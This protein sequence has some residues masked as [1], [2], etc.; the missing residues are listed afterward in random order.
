MQGAP[1]IR[2]V[3]AADHG[4]ILA[5]NNAAY[6]AMNR[7]DDAALAALVASAAYA[8]VACDEAGVAAFL[9]GLPPGVP[10]DSAN[11]RWVSARYPEF[12]YV[13][14]IAVAPRAQS[15]GLGGAL[16]D[17]MA[18]FARGRWP[19]IL[20]EVNLE[21][22]NTGSERFHAR[23]GFVAVGELDHPSDGMY[24][25]RTLMLCRAPGVT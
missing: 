3:T 12:L 13:D 19:C 16:Y 20:A 11:Y 6:P 18:A 8:R 22:P 25:K 7:L 4:A 24:A 2:D 5:I 10:Y 15:R 21:P 14:R 17:D 1:V 23:H 9:L